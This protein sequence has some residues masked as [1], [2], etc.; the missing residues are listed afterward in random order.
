MLTHFL[1]KIFSK[2]YLIHW[3]ISGGV[4]LLLLAA[5]LWYCKL[6]VQPERVFWGMIE[7]SLRTRGVTMQSVQADQTSSLQQTIQFSLGAQVRAL[8]DATVQQG[9]AVVNTQTI[10]SHDTD[11]L[12]YNAIKSMQ[13]DKFGQPKDYSKLLGVWTQSQPGAGQTRLLSQALLGL[14]SPLGGVPVPIGELP[15]DARQK[16][17]SHIKK[18]QIYKT[19]F[20]KAKRETANGRTYLLYDVDIQTIAYVD[21]MKRFAQAIGLHDLDQLDPNTYQGAAPI[22]VTLKVD[23]R[24]RRLVEVRV[25]GSEFKQIFA[26]YDIPLDKPLP[27]DAIT[28]DELQQRLNELQ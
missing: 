17:L 7:Q 5:G 20:S 16:L 25:A 18:E 26:G 8:S 6:S 10:G 27:K 28:S 24:A 15:P 9:D 2:K 11:Y 23:A 12:R 14:S 19:D 1:S 13:R 3:L 22:K 4:I 21:L